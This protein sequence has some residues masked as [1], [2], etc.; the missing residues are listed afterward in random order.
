VLS[1]IRVR[2]DEEIEALIVRAAGCDEV[3]WQELWAALEPRLLGLVRKPRFL[4]QLADNEDACRD[5]VLAVMERLR[6]EDFKRLKVYLD[7]RAHTPTLSFYAWLSIVAKRVGIDHMRAMPEYI[8][9]RRSKEPVSSPGKWL[10]PVTFTESKVDAELGTF[11][12]RVTAA[13]LLEHARAEVSGEQL[14]ALEL[15]LQDASFEE[16][17]RAI[18][19]SDADEAAR[20]VRAVLERLRRKFRHG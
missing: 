1:S 16:I 6:Q 12:G 3:A 14:R 19:V 4:G 7:A 20:L 5:I 17:A 13:E 18:A 10:T 8:D 11:T 15:W 9:R 2:S